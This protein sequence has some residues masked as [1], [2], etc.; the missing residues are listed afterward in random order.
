MLLTG[1]QQRE[2]ERDHYMLGSQYHLSQIFPLLTATHTALDDIGVGTPFAHMK[3][4]S[5][6]TTGPS[7]VPG[8]DSPPTSWPGP[9]MASASFTVI[10]TLIL[11]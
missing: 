3:N 10:P 11:P 4:R 8:R 1:Q 9:R 6:L 7:R 2:A 5:P